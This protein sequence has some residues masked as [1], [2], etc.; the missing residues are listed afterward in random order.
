MKLIRDLEIQLNK[1]SAEDVLLQFYRKIEHYVHT[2]PCGCGQ[3]TNDGLA[4][5]VHLSL[6]EL[7][8]TPRWSI[9]TNPLDEKRHKKI[10][11]NL[12]TIKG[13]ITSEIQ[14]DQID[15]V[16]LIKQLNKIPRT[17]QQLAL[18]V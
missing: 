18:D 9:R 1:K 5:A 8:L 16:E 3:S 14:F 12:E 13:W 7:L 6:S 17:L 15:Q 4:G 11:H 2:I 10:V